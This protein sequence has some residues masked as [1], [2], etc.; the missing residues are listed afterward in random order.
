MPRRIKSIENGEPMQGSKW[1]RI[2]SAAKGMNNGNNNNNKKCVVQRLYE[3]CIETFSALGTVRLP[4][5][6][7]NLQS[8]LVSVH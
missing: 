6:I 2:P 3:L 7:E 8:F 1:N 4:E 5:A